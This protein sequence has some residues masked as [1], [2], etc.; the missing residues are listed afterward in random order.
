MPRF[1]FILCCAFSLSAGVA[2]ASPFEVTSQ[3]P[4]NGSHIPG[5]VSD[6]V[7]NFDS[8]YDPASVDPNDPEVVGLLPNSVTLT[9]ADTLTFH[10]LI[11]FT[12]PNQLV[13]TV[14]QGA[15]TDINGEPN[16]A[17]FGTVTLAAVPEPAT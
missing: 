16:M 6:F 1:A 8:P 17:Y 13:L 7:L 2:A 15:L 14:A 10:Y 3:V 5:P 4:A 9:D 11:P 12:A